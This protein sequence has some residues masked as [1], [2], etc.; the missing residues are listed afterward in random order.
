MHKPNGSAEPIF[1]VLNKAPEIQS[2][3]RKVKLKDTK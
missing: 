1:Q 3:L 2:K